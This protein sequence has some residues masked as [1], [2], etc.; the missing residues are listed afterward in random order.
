MVI[1]L[2]VFRHLHY[3]K[4]VVN[5]DVNGQRRRVKVW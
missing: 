2:L 5:E 4:W 1:T 3:D